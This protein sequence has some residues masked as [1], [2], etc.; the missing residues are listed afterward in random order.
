MKAK[1]CFCPTS[2]P[3]VLRG[4]T[5]LPNGW[6]CP[7]CF[8]ERYYITVVRLPISK[9]LDGYTREQLSENL[10]TVWEQTT[11]AANYVINQL[12]KADSPRK[13]GQTI[14]SWSK[15]APQLQLYKALTQH[16]P[17][18][19]TR[20]LSALE[21][22]LRGTYLKKR[23]WR[24]KAFWTGE[25][26]LPVFR[27]PQPLQIPDR[28]TYSEEGVDRLPVIDFLLAGARRRIQLRT[29]K[30]F[31]HQL[32]GLRKLA[33][34]E[35]FQGPLTIYRQEANKSDNRYKQFDK[36]KTFTEMVSIV[37]WLPKAKRADDNGE[38]RHLYLRTDLE[39]FLV[40]HV[41]GDETWRYNADHVKR[42]IARH[43][44]Q[45]KRLTEDRKFHRK[46]SVGDRTKTLPR[47]EGLA[48]TQ[49]KRLADF[50]GLTASRFTDHCIRHRVTRVYF[51]RREG[52]FSEHFP[53]SLFVQKL[54]TNL[55]R[56]RI[57]FI[58]SD[59]VIE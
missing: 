18:I 31:R 33:N 44:S 54:G 49:T 40:A 37:L 1:C 7:S 39:S 8:D 16:C 2:K 56:A 53:I 13:P 36:K 48:D 14:K 45:L 55:G 41:K 21:H 57:N 30:E 25:A 43:D 9:T 38:E 19:P 20:S 47:S 5:E 10:K 42:W 59:V 51:T 12:A 52:L 46:F 22:R 27:Y 34:G 4:W 50:C 28:W 23:G 29:G 32:Y 15:S 3:D 6:A 24:Y 58:D 17:D 35:A 26:V 11:F